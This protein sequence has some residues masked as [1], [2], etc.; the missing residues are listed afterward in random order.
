MLIHTVQ[1]NEVNT[2]GGGRT[3]GALRSR[4]S[5]GWMDSACWGAIHHPASELVIVL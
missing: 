5:Q 3:C 4:K 2:D 1:V